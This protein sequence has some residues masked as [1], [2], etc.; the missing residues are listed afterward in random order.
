MPIRWRLALLFAVVTGAVMAAAGV[1]FAR[2][3]LF[4]LENNLDIALRARVVALQSALTHSPALSATVPSPRL[5]PGDDGVAQVV[6]ESGKVIAAT[7][8]AG[9]T[10]LMTPFQ[11]RRARSGTLV[12]QDTLALPLLSDDPGRQRVRLLVEPLGHGGRVVIVGTSLDTVYDATARTAEELLVLGGVAVLLAGVG[13]Y[14]LAGAAL[15][16]VERLRAQAA[17]MSGMAGDDRL[18]VPRTR[19]ELA[20]LAE[21]LNAMLERLEATAAQER[22]FFADAGHELRTP[23]AILKGELELA[24]RPGRSAQELRETIGVAAAETDRLIA[25]SEALLTLAV[26][27]S[28]PFLQTTEVDVG[29]LLATAAR[30]AAA[31]ARMAG[32]RIELDAAGPLLA[33]ADAGRLRQAL[34]NLI[35]N[36][37][38]FAPPGSRVVLAAHQG[39]DA[40][41]V[42]VSDEGPGFAPDVLPVVFER[43]RRFPSPETTET[44]NGLGLAIV[45]SIVW[46]H[47]GTVTAANRAPCGAVVTLTLPHTVVRTV[48][49]GG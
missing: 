6:T 11:L 21:T 10:P 3:L 17:T 45:R 24:A 35:A 29:E 5:L 36:A 44:G 20:R 37:L 23:L 26:A 40:V 2:S 38:R 47:G 42:S 32:V 31:Q 22:D 18:A 1:L 4:G 14:L 27:E 33:R 8:G 15:R 43:F 49:A 30:L 41:T 16:P 48:V 7:D 19:D 13:A 46:A 12:V 39:R 34:D 9:D 28:P 25:L